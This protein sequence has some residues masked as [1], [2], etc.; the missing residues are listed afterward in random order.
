MNYLKKLFL[1]TSIMVFSASMHP[2]AGYAFNPDYPNDATK[3]IHT[4]ATIG[5]NTI[6]INAPINKTY[7]ISSSKSCQPCMP[8]YAPSVPGQSWIFVTMPNAISMHNNIYYT[9]TPPT[10]I[11]TSVKTASP[12]VKTTAPRKK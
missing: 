6:T 5:T 1:F 10:P 8:E 3:K 9:T 4:T 12:L 11:S 2:I 7:T